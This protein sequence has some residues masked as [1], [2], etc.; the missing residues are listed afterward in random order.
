MRLITSGT[1]TVFWLSPVLCW[2]AYGELIFLEFTV[3]FSPLGLSLVDLDTWFWVDG[4]GS[5]PITG[6]SA[7]GV[8]AVAT[9]QHIELDPGDGVVPMTCEW[10]VSES[11]ACTHA[12]QRASVNGPLTSDG[13][14]PA[15]EARARLV[16]G[17]HFE[18]GGD[19][20][21]LPG[22]PDE[23]VTDWQ[24]GAVPVAEVQAVV[25]D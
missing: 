11:D 15:Y 7:G 3:D 13:G 16:F 23:F 5:D 24:S 19:V 17:I 8:V 2:Q 10:T 14:D 4:P 6:T 21:E 20:L 1:A 25:T 18:F 12:Y 22:L 9:P